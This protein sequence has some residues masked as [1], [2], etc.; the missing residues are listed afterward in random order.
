MTGRY[1]L[2]ME[3]NKWYLKTVYT[4]K[5]IYFQK[6]YKQELQDV[7]QYEQMKN[8]IKCCFT[9]IINRYFVF[10]MYLFRQQFFLSDYLIWYFF[11]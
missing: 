5:I 1:V 9:A 2:I 8:N 3:T 4:V 11:L 10:I 7:L 6:L